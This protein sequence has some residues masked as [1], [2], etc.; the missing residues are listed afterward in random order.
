MGIVTGQEPTDLRQTAAGLP[1]SDSAPKWTTERVL[2]IHYWTPML[3]SFR[4]TRPRSFRFTPGHYAR[5]GLGVGD[6][7]VWRPY[8]LV[9]A[10]CDDYLEFVAV[11]VPDGAFSACLEKL[12]VG[13]TMQTGEASYGFLT[14]DQLA[15]GRELW[16]LASGTG[17][18]P[19]LSILRDPAVWQAFERLIVIH[20]VRHSSELAYRDKIAAMPGEDLF[21]GTKARLSYLPVVTREP[22]ATTLSERIPRLLADGRLEQ[23]AAAS[24]SVASSRLMVCG[25]PEM[26]REL[27]Q[28]LS[29]R[30]FATHRRGVPGQM[31]FEK[32]W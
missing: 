22:G 23:A 13:D 8:S 18:G 10:A 29:S 3:L 26:V 12:R 7:I 4:T 17:L 31:A 6:H 21:A 20:S 9:S 27:R 5:L 32:Y 14:I 15:P 24:L 30:G 25:N 2:S 19:F 16:L 28:M 1:A 11:L